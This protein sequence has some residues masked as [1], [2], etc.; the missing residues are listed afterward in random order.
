[1]IE[2][3]NPKLKI[4]QGDEQQ[5]ARNLN[6]LPDIDENILAVRQEFI[7][8]PE[9]CHTLVSHIIRLRRK[10][11]DSEQ[12]KLFMELL[13]EYLDVFL[14]HMDIRWLLSI[15]DTMVDIGDPITSATAMNIVQCINRCNIDSTILVNVVDGRLNENRLAQEIKVPTWGGMIT[16]DIPSGDMIYNMMNRLDSVVSK[17]DLLWKIWCEIKNRSR[18]DQNIVLNHLCSASRFRYQ[19]SF[20]P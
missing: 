12:R 20:F 6:R 18:Q 14:Q 17:H 16:A 2:T 8:K 11:K 3:K 13:E 1:M 9:V 5:I 19:R 10:P 15:C 4:I 7:G